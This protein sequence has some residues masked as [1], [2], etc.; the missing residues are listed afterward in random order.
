MAKP[1][2]VQNLAFIMQHA[3][4]IPAVVQLEQALVATPRKAAD[5]RKAAIAILAAEAPNVNTTSPR[6]R[7]AIDELVAALN[8]SAQ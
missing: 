2:Y 3:A 8:E 4:V 7:A 1:S 5:I 6:L